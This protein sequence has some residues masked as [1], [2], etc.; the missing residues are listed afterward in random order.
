RHG[1]VRDGPAPDRDGATRRR[2]PRTRRRL[3]PGRGRRVHARWLP[4]QLH[5]HLL[6]GIER[7]DSLVWD[8]HK[9]MGLPALN[10]AVLFREN[11]RSYEAFAQEAGYLFEPAAPEEQWFNLGQRTLECTKRGMGATAYCMLRVLGTEW[12]EAQVDALIDRTQRLQSMLEAAPD[13][14]IACPARANILCFRHRPDTDMSDA[15]LD[16]LQGRLRQ[17][18]IEGGDFYIVQARLDGRVWLRTT[19]M[20][21]LTSQEDLDALLGAIRTHA[22]PR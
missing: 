20:N 16:Q 12:F 15:A 5:R 22:K 3:R 17:S 14:E 6:A 4:R 10:T 8:L 1:G 13:F 11:R 2:T 21:P 7:A 19:V 18:V 9:M